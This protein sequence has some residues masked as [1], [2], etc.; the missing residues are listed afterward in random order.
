MRNVTPMSPSVAAAPTT[1]G[2]WFREREKICMVGWRDRARARTRFEGLANDARAYTKSGQTRQRFFRE[3]SARL[4]GE[5]VRG[6]LPGASPSARPV[7][8]LLHAPI[9]PTSPVGPGLPPLLP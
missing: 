9:P 8:T 7:L 6:L 1:R 5:L 2:S 4:R 3:I